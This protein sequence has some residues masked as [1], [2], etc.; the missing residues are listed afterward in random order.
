MAGEAAGDAA[1]GWGPLAVLAGLLP[2][3]WTWLAILVWLVLEVVFFVYRE[4][5]RE[6]FDALRHHAPFPD[7]EARA[8]GG[9]GPWAGDASGHSLAQRHSS[10]AP[11]GPR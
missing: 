10:G 5:C 1:A 4:N 8:P 9:E 3:P 7:R 6:T 2:G 11:L